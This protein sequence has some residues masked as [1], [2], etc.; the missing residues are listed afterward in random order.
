MH[1]HKTVT[2]LC[3]TRDELKK[4]GFFM[5]FAAMLCLVLS[6]S[7]CAS[8][9]YQVVHDE[10]QSQSRIDWASLRYTDMGK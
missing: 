8:D 10:S 3:Y 1:C 2:K 5:K 4:R 9:T 6:L 7:A